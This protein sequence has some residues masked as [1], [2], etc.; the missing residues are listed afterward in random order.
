M[1]HFLQRSPLTG[2][3]RDAVGENV[4]IQNSNKLQA[5]KRETALQPSRFRQDHIS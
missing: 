4:L 1:I 2:R 3:E 5:C